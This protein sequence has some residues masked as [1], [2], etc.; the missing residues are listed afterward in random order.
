M[1]ERAQPFPDRLGH[2]RRRLGGTRTQGHQATRN[3]GNNF[4]RWLISKEKI[5]LLLRSPALGDVAGDFRGAETPALGI[6]ERRDGNR[7]L[8]QL[9]S[10]RRR[11]VS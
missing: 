3:G 9:P 5:L 7:N 11:T 4:Y 2:V 6:L 10:L 8:D 1:R